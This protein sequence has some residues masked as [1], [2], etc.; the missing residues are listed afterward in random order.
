VR[1]SMSFYNTTEEIDTLGMGIE[2]IIRMFT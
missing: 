2:K 1:V